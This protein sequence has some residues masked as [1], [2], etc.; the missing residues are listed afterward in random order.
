MRIAIFIFILFVHS[1]KMYCQSVNLELNENDAYSYFK[2]G[3]ACINNG[4]IDSAFIY[5]TS[6]TDYYQKT[7]N[8]TYLA[9]AYVNL[10]IVYKL[11][12]DYVNAIKFYDKAEI[13]FKEL[14][15]IDQLVSIYINKANIIEI[16][17]DYKKAEQ[18]YLKALAILKQNPLEN[19]QRIALIYN[20]LGIIYRNIGQ[21]NKAIEYFLESIKLK[22]NSDKSFLAYGNL[23]LSYE[24]LNELNEAN[25]YYL[26]TL[27]NIEQYYGKTNIFYALNQMN[28]GTFL[29][30]KKNDRINSIAHLTNA[31]LIYKSVYGEKSTDLSFC[32]NRIGEYY[33]VTHDYKSALIS[34][35]KSLVALAENFNDTID[36]TNPEIRSV[37]SKT[38]LLSTLKN[39]TRVLKLLSENEQAK[40]NYLKSALKTNILAIEVLKQLRTGYLSEESKLYLAGNESDIYNEAIEI[41][42]SLFK[43][44][45]NNYYAHEAL[46]FA[47][48]GKATILAEAM[49]N[50]LALIHGNIPPSIINDIAATDKKYWMIEELIYE[51]KRKPNPNLTNIDKWN[52]LLFELSE[53]KDLLTKEIEQKYPRYYELKYDSITIDLKKIQ[54]LLS[55]KEVLIEYSVSNNALYT[56]IITKSKYHLYYQPIDSVF[57]RAIDSLIISIAQN[58][59]AK[60]NLKDYAMFKKTSFT[61]YN[62]L[63]KPY[64][65]YLK[66]KE[67]IIIPDQKL[68]YIPFEVLIKQDINENTLRY[69]Q[70]PYLLFDNP[71]SYSY[72]AKL[73]SDNNHRK[74]R[75]GQKIITLAPDYKSQETPNPNTLQ[76]RQQYREKL[77][78]LKGTKVEAIKIAQL[79]H[80]DTLLDENASEYNFKRQVSDYDLLHLAM[81]TI[82]NDKDPMFSKMAF[83]V[84][85]DTIEDGFLNTFEVYNLKL[86][87]RMAVLSSCNTGSG[88]LNKGEGVMSLARGFIYA[89]CPSIIMTLWTVEDKSGVQLMINFYKALQHGNNKAKSLQKAKIRFLEQADP[90]K[91]HPYYWSGYVAI[92]NKLPLFSKQ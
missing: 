1:S 73:Y 71:I 17:K 16:Q 61:L 9:P 7:N 39:K 18:Y 79:L 51:E 31:L 47:E 44:S 77:F 45:G 12:G 86:N 10:G 20:N 70:L 87:C 19:K 83:S 37:L 48:L 91:S 5:F 80:G 38:H 24:K 64:T 23:A 72:S 4:K 76:T 75:T 46:R 27:K 26:E 43:T 36:F 58:N 56:F 13:L 40:N 30:N 33:L 67:L 65:E 6:I 84:S 52:D 29:V 2:K 89:G 55:R 60:H 28:Y 74:K 62:Y 69:N 21:N 22:G 68:A 8:K 50:N 66:Q 63:I 82:L 34:F 85:N 90:L 14:N 3:Y 35:Q 49:Q 11:Y 25:Q 92:G 57:Y 59:L 53:D 41:C 15:K 54:K 32:Y 42:Y 78:P 81:H 88:L